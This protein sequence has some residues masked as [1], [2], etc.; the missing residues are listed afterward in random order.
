[1]TAIFCPNFPTFTYYFPILTPSMGGFPG[2]IGF[3]FGMGKLEWLGYYLVKFAWWSISRL[4]T[5]HQRDRHTE[6]HVATANAAPTHC[7]GRKN[8]QVRFPNSR[9]GSKQTRFSA[10]EEGGVVTRTISVGDLLNHDCH[11]CYCFTNIY[12]TRWGITIK[13]VNWDYKVTIWR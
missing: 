10:R 6:S 12:S 7:V 4:G 1:M 9:H 2:A 11:Y 3:I 13:Y 5:V 8:T